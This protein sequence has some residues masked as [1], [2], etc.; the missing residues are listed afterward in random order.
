MIKV[1]FTDDTLVRFINPETNR[2]E[3]YSCHYW[4]RDTMPLLS[5]LRGDTNNIYCLC[6]DGE[7]AVFDWKKIKLETVE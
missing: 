6:T 5:L 7:I 1:T 4:K 3:W 2:L